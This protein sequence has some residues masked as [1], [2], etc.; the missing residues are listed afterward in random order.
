MFRPRT[1]KGTIAFYTFETIVF[2]IH[3]RYER[4]YRYK[5]LYGR[6]V[7]LDNTRQEKQKQLCQY[8]QLELLLEPFK[9][10]QENIQPNLV[11]RDGE[12]I[13]EIDKMRMLV[14]R[15]AGRVNQS[16]V[17]RLRDDD[18]ETFLPTDADERMAKLL[19]LT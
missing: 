15:V 19:D 1:K 10:P 9:N 14:A 18:S 4:K 7:A 5:A 16:N 8:K 3:R 13:R 6:L 2:F 11:T 12:L 17:A